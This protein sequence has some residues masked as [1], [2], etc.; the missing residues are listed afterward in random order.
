MGKKKALMIFK[1]STKKH[2]IRYVTGMD[3]AVNPADGNGVTQA[4]RMLML[5]A[6]VDSKYLQP[7]FA[8]KHNFI[9]KKPYLY[10]SFLTLKFVNGQERQYDMNTSTFNNIKGE[11]EYINEL[12]EFE[13]S[14]GGQDDEL[15]DEV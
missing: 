13:R 10:P 11:V 14:F 9:E 4:Q 12:V 2:W 8:Y 6:T 15:D 5:L 3:M 7:G 1:G